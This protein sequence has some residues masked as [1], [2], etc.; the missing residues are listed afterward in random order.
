MDFDDPNGPGHPLPWPV[1]GNH[2]GGAN[3]VHSCR[4]DSR[5]STFSL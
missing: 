1:I 2:P 5:E 3:Y 4:H